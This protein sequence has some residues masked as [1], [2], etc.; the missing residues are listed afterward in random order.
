MVYFLGTAWD[1][2]IGTYRYG[3]M[4]AV[5]RNA[6]EKFKFD[7]EASFFLDCYDKEFAIQTDFKNV[8][9]LAGMPVIVIRT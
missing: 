1:T 3:A 5:T 8:S 9:W 6:D 7:F 4:W 2:T